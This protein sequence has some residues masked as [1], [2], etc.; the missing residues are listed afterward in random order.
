MTV[1]AHIKKIQEAF[2]NWFTDHYRKEYE[3]LVAGRKKCDGNHPS[4][5]PCDDYECWQRKVYEF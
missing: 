2:R 4:I 1:E 3:R 5:Q